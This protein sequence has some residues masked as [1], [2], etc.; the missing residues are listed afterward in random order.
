MT[1]PSWVTLQGIGH[2]FIELDKAVS[3]LSVW[4]V[5]CDCGFHSVCPQMDE[6]KRL[7]EL[8]D[9]R[10]WLWGRLGLALVAK[11]L[12]SNFF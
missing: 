7:V 11:V 10:D 5:F 8:P 3:M 12:F 9:G 4:L 1:H 2:S 6:D